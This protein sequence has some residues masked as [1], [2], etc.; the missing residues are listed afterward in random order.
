MSEANI[1]LLKRAM[2]KETSVLFE[3]EDIH[4]S[5]CIQDVSE[6]KEI[7]KLRL[8]IKLKHNKEFRFIESSTHKSITFR[9]LQKVS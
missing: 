9:P 4:V 1:N 6:E 8:T 7:Y 3:D 2:L 5:H